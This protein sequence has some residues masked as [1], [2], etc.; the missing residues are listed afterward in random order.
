[1]NFYL[2]IKVESGGGITSACIRGLSQKCV[3]TSSFCVIFNIYKLCCMSPER[4]IN[5]DFID[6]KIVIIVLTAIELWFL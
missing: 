5:T 3:D 1:M 2:Y 4:L 6:T